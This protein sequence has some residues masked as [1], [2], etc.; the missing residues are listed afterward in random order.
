MKARICD[1]CMTFYETGQE[2]G[3]HYKIKKVS[4]T[5]SRYEKS[6]DLCPKCTK[7]LTQWMNEGNKKRS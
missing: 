5:S 7:E 2:D 1:R 3:D 4:N 6:L